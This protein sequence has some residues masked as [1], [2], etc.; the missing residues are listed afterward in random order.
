MNNIKTKLSMA[1][2]NE[3][4]NM[5]RFTRLWIAGSRK[6]NATEKAIIQ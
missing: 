4:R 1:T 2:M 6:K 5:K 3:N